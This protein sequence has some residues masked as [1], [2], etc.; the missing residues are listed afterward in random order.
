MA[1]GGRSRRSHRRCRRVAASWKSCSRSCKRRRAMR[2][3]IVWGAL[4]WMGM[5]RWCRSGSGSWSR[6]RGKVG[7]NFCSGKK[8]KKKK[9]RKRLQ[10]FC[11]L[12]L[13][14]RYLFYWFFW[15]LIFISTRTVRVL[16]N[17]IYIRVFFSFFLYVTESMLATIIRE[18]EEKN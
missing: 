12:F 7:R 11:V 16:P 2:I 1:R 15:R 8:K 3:T 6:R 5:G 17:Y 4:T 13:E 10:R 18:R 14:I 9:R